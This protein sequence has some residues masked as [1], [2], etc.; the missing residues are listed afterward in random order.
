L[1]AAGKQMVLAYPENLGQPDFEQNPGVLKVERFNLNNQ[2][3]AAFSVSVQRDSR[4]K[5]KQF[6]YGYRVSNSSKAKQPISRFDVIAPQ[7]GG[8]DSMIAPANWKAASAPSTVYA[9]RA[10]IGQASGIFMSWYALAAGKSITPG[11]ELPGFGVSS[12]LK[13][14][15][16]IAYVRGGDN[17]ALSSEMPEAVLMQTVPVMQFESNSQNVFTIGPKFNVTTRVEVIAKDFEAGIKRLI[18]TKQLDPESQALQEAQRMLTAL[19]AP[20]GATVPLRFPTKPGLEAELIAA[21]R[22]SL[23]VP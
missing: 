9:V 22:L 20:A 4:P 11:S 23:G 10:S 17:P 12:A 19:T 15:L 2:V 21:M 5:S 7:F 1:D 8:N 18:E 3:E 6:I 13:P 14:G 16:V